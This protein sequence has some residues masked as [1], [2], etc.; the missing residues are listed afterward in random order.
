MTVLLAQSLTA[1]EIKPK[2]QGGAGQPTF[3]IYGEGGATFTSYRSMDLFYNP[4]FSSLSSFHVGA[5]VNVR[6]FK[7]N[8][9]SVKDGL[10][11]IQAGVLYTQGGFVSGQQTVKGDYLC[12]PVSF[13]LYPVKNLFLEAG[14]EAC[15]N[16]GLTPEQFTVGED[17][18]DLRGL[19]AND[20]KLG[21]GAG[22]ILDTIP[23]GIS[24]KYL[25]GTSN[26]AKNLHWKSNQ[27][28]ISVFYRFK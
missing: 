20:L 24:V 17:T 26:F 25:M 23:L 3:S 9:V 21:I 2:G 13:Q 28:R 27:L 19:R 11:G 16:L 15:L 12:I 22:F 1:E 6:F 4:G 7:R 14:P 18:L 5:G 10:L 8:Q